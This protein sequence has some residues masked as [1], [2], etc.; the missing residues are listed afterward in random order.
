MLATFRHIRKLVD[1]SRNRDQRIYLFT[2]LQRGGWEFDNDRE[3]RRFAELLKE[4]S[5]RENIRIFIHDVGV[6]D[7]LNRA[8]VD[9]RVDKRVVTTKRKTR[10]RTSIHN[11]SSVPSRELSVTL[12]IDDA[13]QATQ[14]T[15]LPP[16][17][18]TEL[19]F[20]YPF[21]SQGPHAVRVE[22]E[23]DYLD[24]DDER[25]LSLEVRH[26]LRGLV[27]DGEP[28][29]SAWE[30]ETFALN[31]ALDPT[32]EG[33]YFSI[34]PRTVELFSGEGLDDHDFLVLAN[35]AGLTSDKADPYVY[36]ILRANVEAN[37]Y[38][39]VILEQKAVSD[40]LGE[41]N[42]HLSPGN[43][44]DHRLYDSNDGRPTIAVEVITLDNYFEN[45]DNRVDFIKMD[46]QGSEPGAFSGMTS[47]IQSNETLKLTSEL[48][49]AGLQ[50]FGIGAEKYLEMLQNAG[51]HIFD[52]DESVK[53]LRLLDISTILEMYPAESDSHTNLL[54][55][56]EPLAKGL[57]DLTAGMTTV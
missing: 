38:K 24:V 39:N 4:L 23:T 37:G 18:T 51:L 8:V 9:L 57:E 21:S 12:Y 34:T 33:R 25:H 14:T 47:L 27:V 35:V 7:A 40:R 53:K 10:F 17:A 11:F 56:K 28:K 19:D 45:R 42:L 55:V 50:R 36:E 32:R 6:R 49:P 48:W 46:I 16:N 13:P 20:E 3:A 22:I 5:G 54:M 44:G 26:A 15:A 2:D 41:A 30:S 1:K 29:G 43:M 31:L 52:I